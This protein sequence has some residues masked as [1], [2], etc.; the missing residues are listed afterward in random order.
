[1]Y[2]LTWPGNAALGKLRQED[3]DLQ[4]SLSYIV[5]SWLTNKIK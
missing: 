3:H 1:M 2:Y 4:D 5:R